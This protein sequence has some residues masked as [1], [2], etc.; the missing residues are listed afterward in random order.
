MASNLLDL[1]LLAK[2]PELLVRLEL[3]LQAQQQPD[4]ILGTVDA[5]RLLNVSPGE[6]RALAAA[7]DVPALRLGKGWQFSRRQLLA[8]FAAQAQANLTTGPVAPLG[9]A[10]TDHDR[11]V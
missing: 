11:A 9:T 4:T 8:W 3:V 5:A 6:L 1:D 2:V 7:G 10:A